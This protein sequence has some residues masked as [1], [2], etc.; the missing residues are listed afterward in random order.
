MPMCR[1]SRWLTG[2]TVFLRLAERSRYQKGKPF[3]PSDYQKEILQEGLDVGMAMA[4]A[5]GFNKTKLMF[6]TSL[7]GTDSGWEDA[8]AGMNPGISICR[9]IRS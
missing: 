6:P 2:P 9:R 8:M 7:Y 1:T 4:Q 5:I 3:G